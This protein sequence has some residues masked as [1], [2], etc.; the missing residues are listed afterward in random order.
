[1]AFLLYQ[2]CGF[3]EFRGAIGVIIIGS[4]K[5]NRAAAVK[6]KP[7]RLTAAAAPL[8]ERAIL[9]R[10]VIFYLWLPERLF[11]R[12][13]RYQLCGL[14]LL[15]LTAPVSAETWVVQIPVQAADGRE[16][17]LPLSL[18]AETVAKNREPTS[19]TAIAE[20]Y[21]R[22]SLAGFGWSLFPPTD[23]SQRIVF[24]KRG[25]QFWTTQHTDD[26]SN[27]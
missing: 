18:T 9:N 1:L 7:Q 24:T 26:D 15:A 21:S 16:V 17:M 12:F 4:A 23:A 11:M 5:G 2:R 8:S 27:Y 10:Q 22:D 3:A 19:I 14:A 25:A 13:V 20:T 6:C